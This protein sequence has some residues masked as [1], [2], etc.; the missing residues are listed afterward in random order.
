MGKALDSAE[1]GFG[2]RGRR[3]YNQCL[4]LALPS[5][6]QY[7]EP[8]SHF[9]GALEILARE[10]LPPFSSPFL[11]T[12]MVATSAEAHLQRLPHS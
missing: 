10:R 2:T 8:A 4:G 12:R 5:F 3:R 9:G 7:A 11:Q 1:P 6:K